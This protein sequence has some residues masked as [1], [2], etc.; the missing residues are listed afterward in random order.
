MRTRSG[1]VLVHVLLVG[2]LVAIVAGWLGRLAMDRARLAARQRESLQG[3]AVAEAAYLKAANCLQRLRWSCA[4]PLTTPADCTACGDPS[5][6]AT[7]GSFDLTLPGDTRAFAVEVS[8]GGTPPDCSLSAR[9]PA[10]DAAIRGRYPFAAGVYQDLS[11]SGTTALSTETGYE[12]AIGRPA[13]LD[14]SDVTFGTLSNSLIV[15]GAVPTLV[16]RGASASSE[17]APAWWARRAEGT[18]A[19]PRV[20]ASFGFTLL[21]NWTFGFDGTQ[22][23]PAAGLELRG[24][25][26]GPG[27]AAGD[28]LFQTSAPNM[29]YPNSPTNK[30][31][32]F[33]DGRAS[34]GWW[35]LVPT[36]PYIRVHTPDPLYRLKMD[37]TWLLRRALSLRADGEGAEMLFRPNLPGDPGALF[38]EAGITKSNRDFKI[39]SF[40][41][42]LWPGGPHFQLHTAGKFYIGGTKHSAWNPNAR[43]ET[44][45]GA[46]LT[47]TG[48]WSPTSS[49]RYKTN[50]EPLSGTEAA[51]ALEQ[52][53]PVKFVY[54]AA[55]D[56]PTLGFIAEDVP[57]LVAVKGR[58]SVSASEIAA[59][60]A[61]ALK[62]QLLNSDAADAELAELRRR[63]DAK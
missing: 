24:M 6:A 40:V 32:L 7:F 15:Q 19:A 41:P 38:W 12:T 48:V 42:S 27:R 46:Y 30:M 61:G 56:E 59:V 58:R 8:L 60:I 33:S 37:G 4:A 2:L 51:R 53:R 28:W 5:C 29:L 39:F 17:A 10:Q 52:L 45:T 25:G 13:Q 43:L 57:E 54:Q 34:I 14:S 1:L 49:R 23:W 35:S 44:G 18:L 55:P 22:Y 16:L 36:P 31:H 62:G 63:L 9:A 47:T 20:S 21:E 3:R 26:A 11:V 50:I